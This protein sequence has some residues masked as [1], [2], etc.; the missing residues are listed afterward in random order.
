MTGIGFL[1]AGVIFNEGL[2]VRGL[3]TAASIWITAAIGILDRE[4]DPAPFATPGG[5]HQ[6]VGHALMADNLR[7]RFRSNE[8]H[9]EVV[10]V[11]GRQLLC[12]HH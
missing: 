10:I 3:T 1:G 12:V 7:F 9:R 11:L 6:G 4:K 5:I 8:N 2:T